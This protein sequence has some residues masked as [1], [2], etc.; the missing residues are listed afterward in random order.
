MSELLADLGTWVS[1]AAV[2]VGVLVLLTTKAPRTALGVTLDLLLAAGLLRLSA[3]L[4]WPA[5][6]TAASII[7][8]RKVVSEALRAS[9]A[10]GA[11]A[12]A[13]DL[14]R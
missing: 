10:T 12:A 6:G 13:T 5:I 3:S 8:V 11:D 9:P 7:A 14:S 2:A 4:D 1:A